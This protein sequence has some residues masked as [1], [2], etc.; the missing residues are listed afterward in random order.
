MKVL[1]LA[2]FS[3]VHSIRWLREL[4]NEGVD[5]IG[6]S[7]EKPADEISGIRYIE[8]KVSSNRYKY[9]LALGEI[10]E[11]IEEENPDILNPHFLPNYGLVSA[12]LKGRRPVVLAIWGSDLLKVSKKSP[13]HRLISERVIKRADFILVD[14]LNLKDD[15]VS[16]GYD[17]RRIYVLTFGVDER[18]RRWKLDKIKMDIPK[19]VTH[20]R[21]EPHMD[22]F[23]IIEALS[24]LKEKNLN[25]EF[26]FA[27]SYGYLKGELIKR[28]GELGLDGVNFV[29]SPLDDASLY[30]L[31]S[32]HHI[33]I[34]ASLWDST[35]VSLLEAMALGLFPIVSNI[36][37]NRE[38]IVDGLNGYLFNVGEPVDLA[39]KIEKAIGNIGL[40][41]RA[42]NLNKELLENRANWEKHIKNVIE[43]METLI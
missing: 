42:R 11:I 13:F 36:P 17:P 40:M 21:L 3:S 28:R 1:V 5:A 27:S 43:I 14:G 31:L 18:L 8:P 6:L 29:E 34:S 16:F 30:E 33:Y 4:R 23:T 38:W 19:I 12:I 10:R 41:E 25:F 39:F 32:K 37:A 20:R 15:V 26:T 35:S 24:I 22:P 9:L 2:D 7:L